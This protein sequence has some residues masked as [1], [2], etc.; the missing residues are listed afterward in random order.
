MVLVVVV[1]VGVVV[2]VVVVEN[3]SHKHLIVTGS[4]PQY[5]GFAWKF[6]QFVE[7]SQHWFDELHG[8]VPHAAAAAVAKNKKSYQKD[9]I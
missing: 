6:T 7:L 2:P 9:L 8:F 4:R 5:S 3:G 1:G